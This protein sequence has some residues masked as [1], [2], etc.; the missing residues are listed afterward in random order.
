MIKVNESIV[1]AGK[2]P[3]GETIFRRAFTRYHSQYHSDY[4]VI[5][6]QYEN[7]KDIFELM[8][9]KKHL[10]SVTSKKIIL[11]MFYVPYSRM[12]REIEG[13]MFSLK[14]FCQIINDM[15]FH[16]IRVLDVHSNV[17]SALLNKCKEID[18]NNI[19]NET[20]KKTNADY[21]F[22][23]D[24]GACKRYSEILNHNKPVFYGNKARDL[25]TGEITHYELINAPK[26][27]GKNVLIID[28]LCS[29]G[30]TFY[31]AGLNL[32]EAGANNINLYVSHCENSIHKGKIFESGLFEGVYTTNS[33]LTNWDN[34]LLNKVE[35]L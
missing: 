15:N 17:T 9:I 8:M 32:Q 35:I 26:L 13:Y 25:Q 27:K 20:I 31:N 16:M 6:L 28:D 19:V 18:I 5:D 7:D 4:I 12:D 2:Y 14:H 21:V 23:P 24:Q 3:N 29:K 33:I 11:N 34:P 30:F 10:D 22:Y 1:S